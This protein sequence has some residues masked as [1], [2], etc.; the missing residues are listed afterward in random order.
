[1]RSDDDI[2]RSVEAELRWAPE[3][4]ATDITVAV[5]DGVVTL[6][7]F[8]LNY[9]DKAEAESAAQ[10]VAG[11]VAVTN[12]IEV[13]ILGTDQRLDPIIARDAVAAIRFEC[14]HVDEDIRVVV[15]DGR[16]PL[17][18][19]VEWNYVRERAEA[20]LRRVKGIKGITNLTQLKPM[21][22]PVELRRKIE[23]ALE[24]VADLDESG[25][26]VNVHGGTVVLEGTLPMWWNWKP[27]ER[28]T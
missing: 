8:V 27:A 7:G 10:R 17:D 20:T 25:I 22:E 16:V 12:D 11:V 24:R 21:A 2:K 28:V 5:K 9:S 3:I 19:E 1:M 18:G 6:A 26:S 13:R 23:E 4:D 15:K 14:P